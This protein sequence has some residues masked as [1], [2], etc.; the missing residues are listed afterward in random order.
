MQC[1]ENSKIHVTVFFGQIQLENLGYL[2]VT[3]TNKGQ[4]SYSISV[5]SDHVRVFPKNHQVVIL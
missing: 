1:N 3:A 2:F 5:A 4:T